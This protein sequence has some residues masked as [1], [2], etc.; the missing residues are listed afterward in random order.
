MRGCCF[1]ERASK[2]YTMVEL[3]TS[4]LSSAVFHRTVAKFSGCPVC[5]DGETSQMSHLPLMGLQ[6]WG[7]LSLHDF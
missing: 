6:S 1:Q 5:G 4:I 2:E 7:S 3:N